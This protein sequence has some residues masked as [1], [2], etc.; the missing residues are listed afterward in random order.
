VV[1]SIERKRRGDKKTFVV[2]GDT[3]AERAIK[4]LRRGL[5][6]QDEPANG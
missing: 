4:L 5:V 2:V 3:I 6:I 1:T